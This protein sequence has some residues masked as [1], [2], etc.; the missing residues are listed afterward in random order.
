MF[1]R[2]AWIGLVL[3]V[4]LACG[5]LAGAASFYEKKTVKIV[6]VHAPGGGYD[7][8]SRQIGRASCRERV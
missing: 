6:S 3:A 1:R 5:S 2:T 7:T 4:L 8:Y